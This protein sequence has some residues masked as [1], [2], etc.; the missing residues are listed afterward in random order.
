MWMVELAMSLVIQVIPMF[1][2]LTFKTLVMKGEGVN[3]L[4]AA[5][6]AM[7]IAIMLIEVR[8]EPSSHLR[9]QLPC[10]ALSPLSSIS[11]AINAASTVFPIPTS[12]A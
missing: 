2:E 9:H 6:L 1:A 8:N 7:R 3:M 4:H 11:W 12:S 10:L 5:R